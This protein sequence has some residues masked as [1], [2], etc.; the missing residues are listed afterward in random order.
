[1]KQVVRESFGWGRI[2]EVES[3]TRSES[4]LNSLTIGLNESGR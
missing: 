1:M 4:V 3:V 2:E